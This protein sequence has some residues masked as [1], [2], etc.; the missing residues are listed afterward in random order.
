ME[1]GSDVQCN[2]NRSGALCGMCRSGFSLSLGSSHCVQCSAQ[3]PL[4]FVAILT[5]AFLAGVAL[6]AILLFLNLTVATGVLNGIIFY[7]N[8]IH[9]N[10]STFFPFVERNY[11]TVFIAWLNLELG[12]DTCLF[13]GM[14]TY[15]K[16][17][18]QLAFPTYV[19]CLVVIV[20]LISEFSTKF[21]RLIG[22]KDPVATLATFILLSYTR[23]LQTITVALSFSILDYPNGSRKVVWLP[24]GTVSYLRG[25]HILLFFIAMLILLVGIAYTTLL[26]S[27]QW[28]IYYQNKKV[29]KWVR[30]QKFYLF[31]E[32]YHAPYNFN[33]CFWTGLLL[34]VRVV[35]YIASTLNVS[36]APGVDLLVTGI[37]T[38]GLLLLKG[39][40]GSKSSIYRKWPV[41]VLETTCYVNI[42]IIS[43]ARFHT[44]ESNQ[45]ENVVAY[46]SGTITL[47]LFLVVVVCHMFPEVCHRT[48]LCN[49]LGKRRQTPADE[50]EVLL[51]DHPPA[52]GDQ[53]DPPQPTVSWIDAPQRR[54]Q[55]YSAM[56]NVGET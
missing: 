46:I 47:A 40:V 27:W 26:F 28:L 18:L 56:V 50:D 9:A 3:W 4:L 48:K 42:I 31:L 21:A 36:R 25:K 8:V 45:D 12:I 23:F 37:V 51:N 44:L 20:I 49:K 7:A 52:D 32:P 15:W 10:S 6:A 30:Y 33:H 19:I 16:T 17:L 2:F 1:G 29:F 34:L 5:A 38:I 22:R 11:I 41:D 39:H 35:L 55:P 24:D 14:D 54:E 53:R 43:F 13:E